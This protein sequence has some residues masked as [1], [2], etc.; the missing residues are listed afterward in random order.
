[1]VRAARAARRRDPRRRVTLRAMATRRSSAL[2]W[3]I[4]RVG[5]SRIVSRLHP[6]VYRLTGGRGIVGR[7]MGMRHVVVTTVGRRSGTV[8]EIPLYA[9]EDGPRLLL[10]GSYAGRDRDPAWVGNLEANPVLGLRGIRLCLHKRDFFRTQLRALLRVAAEFPEGLVR[11]MFPLI[12]GIE[13]IRVA[14]LLVHQIADE[15]RGEGHDIA[16]L[17][18]L[19]AMVEVPSAALMAE[20]LAGEVEFLSIG[21]NDLIQYTLAV[22]RGNDL[23]ADLYR[24]T[25]PAVLRLIAEVVSAGEAC[26]TEVTMCGEMAADPLMVPVLIGL[27][28]RQ[29]SMNPMAVPVIRSLIR[30]LSYRETVHIARHARE[31]ATARDVE[32]FLLERLAISLAKTKI[33]V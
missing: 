12:S 14:R 26:G 3:I 23:V 30:Q 16:H 17:P 10:I 29:F 32:E 21:T 20:K 4:G 24:P 6:R 7:S 2:Y 15:L 1:M 27:G 18:P 9:T 33:R 19:G 5:T 31:L 22:D 8:R 11:V 25:S 13:E 28:L